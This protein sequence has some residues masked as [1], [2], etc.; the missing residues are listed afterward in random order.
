MIEITVYAWLT[1]LLWGLNETIPVTNGYVSGAV[2]VN[3]GDISKCK[4]LDKTH[5]QAQDSCE[6]QSSREG[7]E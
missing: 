1:E 6:D 5:F 3:I 2:H 4:I 7:W